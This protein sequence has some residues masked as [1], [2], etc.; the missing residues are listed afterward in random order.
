MSNFRY[1]RA[2]VNRE[3]RRDPKREAEDARQDGF[4]GYTEF[5]LVPI[6]DIVP[7]AVWN[8]GRIEKIREGIQ[9][10]KAL[11]PI[12][13]SQDSAGRYHIS[14]GI[15]R[16]N[17]SLEAKFTHVPALVSVMVEAPEMKEPELPERPK[18][19]VGDAVLL[20]EPQKSGAESP[21]AIIEQ[22]L[23]K[24]QH[25]GVTRHHYALVGIRHGVAEFIGDH[26]DDQL[27]IPT[28]SL[29][30]KLAALFGEYDMWPTGMSLRVA[31]RYLT[32][33]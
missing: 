15:H 12:H 19:Q 33:A 16:Y 13:V 18:Q 10:K 7:E 32:R 4:F 5:R 27:D 31:R 14:D 25:R 28:G 9:A 6:R 3:T 22:V 23:Y 2:L 8:P 30:P 20:R 26:R 17:A 1:D 29:P 24:G 21:W 11:P